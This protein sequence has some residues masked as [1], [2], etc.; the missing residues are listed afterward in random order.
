MSK[1]RLSQEMVAKNKNKVLACSTPEHRLESPSRDSDSICDSDAGSPVPFL[2]TQD[3]AEGET[4]VVWNF[5]TPKA[6]HATH[7][8]KNTTPVSRKS[9]KALRPK[10]IEKPLP[11]RKP[12]RQS[13]KRT[14]LFQDLIE[15]NQNLHELIKQKAKSNNSVN[16]PPSGS[17]DDIFSDNSES[18][19]KS[20]LRTSSRCLRKN[21][22]SSKF[23]KQEPEP[24]LESDDSM[25]ECLL[26]AS[27]IVEENIINYDHSAPKRPCLEAL[28]TKNRSNFKPSAK[29][30]M[31]QDSMDTILSNIK[32]ESPVIN[33]KTK[34][35]DSPRLNN[36]SFDNLLGNLNDS[37]LERLSQMPVKDTNKNVTS[38]KDSSWVLEDLTIH[39]ESPTSRSLFGRHNSMPES[40]S[41]IELNKPSTSGMAFGRYNSMPFNKS[42]E[43]MT[44]DSPIRCTQDEIKKKHQQARERLM[45]KRLLPFTTSQHPI[46]GSSQNQPIQK[47]TVFQPKVPS[48]TKGLSDVKN[49][50]SVAK[51]NNNTEQNKIDSSNVKLLIEKK[52]QEALMKL[53]RRQPQTKL[54]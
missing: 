16:K 28:T 54:P 8:S 47:K 22:L 52:R 4:D 37:A 6:E 34:K 7:R 41:M 18:S 51:A 43:K 48:I 19:P 11:K 12:V 38:T 5:Y 46:Q 15:L 31:D 2:C 24:G 9:R 10:L 1:R 40:P 13:Q 26:R 25:N 33:N 44:G 45:A 17:E 32:L 39:G 21:V 27:Q 14:E 30:S 49:N 3:G 29:I 53:R 50:N 23:K 36:D 35:Y 42:D 20:V